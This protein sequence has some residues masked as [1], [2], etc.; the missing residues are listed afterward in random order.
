[1]SLD[2]LD[3]VML[4]VGYVHHVCRLTDEAALSFPTTIAC[5][6]SAAAYFSS[7]LA[8]IW[9]RTSDVQGAAAFFSFPAPIGS[10][11]V[12]HDRKKE[13][14]LIQQMITGHNMGSDV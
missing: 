13:I 2:F 5:T 4:D 14:L 3:E 10:D 1:M 9:C 12:R 8:P 11:L 7:F 6:H